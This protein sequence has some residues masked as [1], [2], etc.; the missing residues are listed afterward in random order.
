MKL[1]PRSRTGRVVAAGLTALVAIGVFLILD[2]YRPWEQPRYHGRPV[3]WW[4]ARA[5]V[6]GPCEAHLGL[7]PAE[8]AQPYTV[9]WDYGPPLWVEWLEA[10]V[11]PARYLGWDP[12]REDW[13]LV[14]DGDPEAV[15][16]LLG[17][18]RRP[19]EEVRLGAV[20]GLTAAAARGSRPAVAGLREAAGDRDEFIRR[21]ARK[22]LEDLGCKPPLADERDHPGAGPAGGE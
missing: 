22:A 19:E 7:D 21:F 9:F 15:P 18:L 17:P 10:H 4:A 16:V 3:S 14:R 5:W 12:E 13:S 8:W 11:L 20:V 2:E 6:R 1:L